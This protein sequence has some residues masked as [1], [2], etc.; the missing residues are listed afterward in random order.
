M[1]LE[2]ARTWAEFALW[3]R[4]QGAG[5]HRG[6]ARRGGEENAVT[7]R[8]VDPEGGKD[9]ATF[10][11]CLAVVSNTGQGAAVASSVAGTP[12][13]FACVGLAPPSSDC[14][15]WGM[16]IVHETVCAQKK[17]PRDPGVGA[18][19]VPGCPGLHLLL[20]ATWGCQGSQKGG[21]VPR[22]T[23]LLD[24][25]CLCRSVTLEVKGVS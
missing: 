22:Q 2:Q 9:R 1:Q 19:P 6:S 8:L 7:E 18:R 5:L 3:G 21:G 12:P 11:R 20:S 4:F 15:P 10:Q 14:D 17:A 23:V 25:G 16:L 24:S 13:W